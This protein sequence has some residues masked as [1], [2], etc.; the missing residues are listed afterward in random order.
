M[1]KLFISV[2]IIASIFLATGCER[3]INLGTD[4][5]DPIGQKAGYNREPDSTVYYD[6]VL[7]VRNVDKKGKII[8]PTLTYHIE[9]GV[10]ILQE[11][12][13]GLYFKDMNGN[14]ILDPYEDWRKST[15]ERAEW[16]ARNMPNEKRMMLMIH[17]IGAT[18]EE[19]K[20][21]RRFRWGTMVNG[22]PDVLA[23]SN[24]RMQLWAEKDLATYGVPV[25]TPSD[26]RHSGSVDTGNPEWDSKNV[27][28]SMWPSHLGLSGT[29]NPQAIYDYSRITALEYRAIGLQMQIAPMIDMITD[30]RWSRAGSCF[31][32]DIKLNEELNRAQIKAIQTSDEIVPNWGIDKG[33]GMTSVAGMAKHW[34]GG[35]NGEFGFDGHH[36]DGKFGVFPSM[37]FEEYLDI[38]ARAGGFLPSD[39]GTTQQSATFMPYYTIPLDQDPSGLNIGNGLSAFMIQKM[40]RNKYDYDGFGVSD[41]GV[42]GQNGH[43]YTDNKGY[44]V[45][46][47]SLEMF[48]AGLD[49]IGGVNASN[50]ITILNN[51]YNAGVEQLGKDAMEEMTYI[52]AKRCYRVMFNLGLFESAYTNPQYAKEFVGS[53]ELQDKAQ[54]E[55]HI[56]SA[57]MLKNKDNVLP[58]KTDGAKKLT[59]YLP[60]NKHAAPGRGYNTLAMAEN[61]SSGMDLNVVQRY[62]NVPEE[63]L[64]AVSENRALT[65]AERASAVAQSDFALMKLNSPRPPNNGEQPQ[66]LMFRPYTAEWQRQISLG[67]DWIHA[68]DSMV[69]FGKGETPNI[70]A[71]D[72]KSNRSIRNGRTHDGVPVSLAVI[73]ETVAAMGSKPIVFA[74][75][76][77]NPMVVSDFEPYVSAIIVGGGISDVAILELISGN[78]EPNGLLSV[79]FPMNMETVELANE[80]SGHDM[81]PYLDETGNRYTFG[82]GLNRSGKISDH[83]TDYY[84]KEILSRE[85]PISEKRGLEDYIQRAKRLDA[86]DYDKAV[87]E[88]LALAISAGDAVYANAKASQTEVNAA[89]EVLRGIIRKLPEIKITLINGQ[90]EN[91]TNIE[92][93][94]TAVTFTPKNTIVLTLKDSGGNVIDVVAADANGK[95]KLKTNGLNLN[96]YTITAKSGG[97]SGGLLL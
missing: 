53:K 71:G 17:S 84:A 56:A 44:D 60:V 36:D 2:C 92:V 4:F 54:E 16:L 87:N 28:N 32:E 18:E 43:G 75:S 93:I 61:Y 65:A 29:F 62:Y 42:H 11:K 91:A 58:I 68:D 38:H 3:Y 64:R 59:V 76:M 80:D 51:A 40:L 63:I 1:K 19:I 26:P 30:P 31:S 24:N 33:W 88:A 57:V 6:G 79:N 9:S 77:T 8:G 90:T 14:G 10:Q 94:A 15:E 46:F 13:S 35:G 66:N 67:Y 70:L 78:R 89:A 86:T 82:F 96:K 73:N 48:K 50:A 55:G 20:D 45:T 21:G 39:K 41:W 27:N 23:E 22:A 12:P 85:Y 72:H 34:P 7:E 37:D 25:I 69:Q 83:R 81:V 52:S 47:R 95:A 49:Q 5:G 97:F 74:L